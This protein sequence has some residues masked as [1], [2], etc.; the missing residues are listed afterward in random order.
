MEMV[1]NR[2][3]RSQH[4]EYCFLSAVFEYIPAMELLRP[5]SR[6]ALFD[7]GPHAVPAVTR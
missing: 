5:F 7:G 2:L 1:E 6:F 4:D 3:H